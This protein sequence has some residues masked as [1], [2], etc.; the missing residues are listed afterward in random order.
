[1]DHALM[2]ALPWLYEAPPNLIRWFLLIVTGVLMFWAG[3]SIF[4]SAV[5]GLR[6]GTTNM[7]TMVAL[8]TSVAFVYSAYSTLWPASNH[9]VAS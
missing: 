1:V 5:R 2:R 6:H 3:G 7:N 8:G 4:A 9:A